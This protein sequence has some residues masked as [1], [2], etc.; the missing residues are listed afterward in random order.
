MKKVSKVIIGILAA[1]G[2]V[3]IICA[4]LLFYFITRVDNKYTGQELFQA[5]ND[6]RASQN[7]PRLQLDPALCN[8]L[9]ERWLAIKNPNNGHAGDEQWLKNEGLLGNSKYG[10]FGELYITATTPENAIN[11]WI[12]SPGHRTTLEMKSMVYG[13]AYANDGI[14]VVEMA[15]KK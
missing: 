9:V 7:I 11:W 5:V 12:G 14:G 13:C 8:N 2:I 10:Q 3:G 6:Y 15:T 4:A 1:A